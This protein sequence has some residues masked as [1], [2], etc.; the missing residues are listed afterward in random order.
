M[1][2]FI[3][4]HIMRTGVSSGT[5]WKVISR[6][7]PC[8]VLPCKM[9]Q[10]HCH[11]VQN[12]HD[13]IPFEFWYRFNQK[14]QFWEFVIEICLHAADRGQWA[15]F[16]NLYT[17]FWV[18]SASCSDQL[19][20]TWTIVHNP[21]LYSNICHEKNWSISHIYQTHWCLSTSCYIFI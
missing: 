17:R 4:S 9:S 20:I 21:L 12:F 15:A 3:V 13:S 16:V 18:W 1:T 6:C 7:F 2:S 10:Q 19:N 5:R 8:R 11:I 14:L